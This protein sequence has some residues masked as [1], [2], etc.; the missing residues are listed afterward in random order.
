M[1][2][3]LAMISIESLS[4]IDVLT[5]SGL[6]CVLHKGRVPVAS[7]IVLGRRSALPVVSVI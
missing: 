5:R 2:C 3:G 4:P 7:S 1:F 6:A